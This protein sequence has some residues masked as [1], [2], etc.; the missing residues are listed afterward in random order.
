MGIRLESTSSL[1]A[2]V[3]DMCVGFDILPSKVFVKIKSNFL[4]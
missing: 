4:I 3:C 2:S 1:K